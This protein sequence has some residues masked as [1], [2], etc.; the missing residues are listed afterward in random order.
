MVQNIQEAKLK[1]G[2]KVGYVKVGENTIFINNRLNLWQ[3]GL[4]IFI[5]ITSILVTYVQFAFMA[6]AFNR[7][8]TEIRDVKIGL[9][10][11]SD[12]SYIVLDRDLSEPLPYYGNSEI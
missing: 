3:V 5:I 12:N 11:N 1:N 2:K 10:L 4:L 6:D 9:G 8:L 7:V